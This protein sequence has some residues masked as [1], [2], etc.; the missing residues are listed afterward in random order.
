MRIV[1]LF[2]EHPHAVGETYTQHLL[3][4]FGFGARMIA[5]GCACLVHALLPFLFC[6]T[7]SRTI[8]ELNEAMIARRGTARASE[9]RISRADSR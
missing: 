6:R 9:L 5:G 2:T 7:G 3:V 4:A 1:E 8:T